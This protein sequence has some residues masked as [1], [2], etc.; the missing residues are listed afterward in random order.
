M[1]D[2]QS[3]GVASAI[4]GGGMT[5]VRAAAKR[6]NLELPAW[7]DVGSGIAGL[8]LIGV[9]L[10][11]LFRSFFTLVGVPLPA[12]SP[13]PTA[14][15]YSVISFALIF[16]AGYLPARF[17]GGESGRKTTWEAPLA[18]SLLT[19]FDNLNLIGDRPRLNVKVIATEQGKSVAEF[20]VKTLRHF[21]C[22][23]EV[24]A[25][26]GSYV[27]PAPTAFQGT[28]IRYRESKFSESSVVFDALNAL[29]CTPQ[30]R[31][32]PDDDRFNFIQVEI[33]D[34]PEGY[35]GPPRFL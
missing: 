23:V 8:A 21:G 33:G 31:Y 3:I 7:V 26:N 1:A 20:L 29:I 9:G 35:S 17:S 19:H 4:L 6:L 32:F 28:I 16:A 11:L 27:F 14:V 24:N 22:T 34:V 10:L 13:W 25:E 15:V 12:D 2:T 30:T 18:E 5:G